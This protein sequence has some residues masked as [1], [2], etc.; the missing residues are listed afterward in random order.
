MNPR[1]LAINNRVA[2][3]IEF[4]AHDIVIT[5]KSK[6]VSLLAWKA[7]FR[8]HTPFINGLFRCPVVSSGIN[9]GIVQE[10]SKGFAV[11]TVFVLYAGLVNRSRVERAVETHMDKVW[12]RRIIM[13]MYVDNAAFTT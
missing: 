3:P 13:W 7:T 10:K 11:E 5:P 2:Q 12:R 4:K 1:R 9:D 6:N 8:W